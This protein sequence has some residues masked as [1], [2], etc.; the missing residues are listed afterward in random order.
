MVPAFTMPDTMQI[1][2]AP[3]VGV[4][5]WCLAIRGP[6]SLFEA[7]RFDCNVMH[8]DFAE[9]RGLSPVGEAMVPL[10][11]EAMCNT[12]IRIGAIGFNLTGMD[13][14]S[15]GDKTESYRRCLATFEVAARCAEVLRAK[16]IYVPSFDAS[17]I[18]S[19]AALQSTAAFLRSVAPL[20]RRRGLRLASENALGPEENR[21]L[22]ILVGPELHVMLDT[23]NPSLWG[24]SAS[25]IAWACREA[26]APQVHLKD[27]VGGV[28]GN[29]PIGSGESGIAQTIAT[30]RSIGFQGDLVLEND[31][32][33][34]SSLSLEADV[35]TTRRYLVALT[36][37]V[38]QPS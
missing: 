25:E 19:E 11:L 27:G 31:Y 33:G 16:M 37:G 26:L 24:H 32:A 1:P 4:A 28:M 9:G 38:D 14:I 17:S 23:Q 15:T 35:A 30:L 8:L 29:S 10:Y 13:S 7:R 5:E 34:Q 6:D 18:E 2:N 21:R 36:V 3:G 12:G 22:L 20:A